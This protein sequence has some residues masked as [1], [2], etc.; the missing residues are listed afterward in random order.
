MV[1]PSVVCPPGYIFVTGP[2]NSVVCESPNS[3]NWLGAV[4]MT[5][6]RDLQH[7]WR[8]YNDSDR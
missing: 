3:T 4:A 8:H 2:D 7:D 5:E 1:A 6:G